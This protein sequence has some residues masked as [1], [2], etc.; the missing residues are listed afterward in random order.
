M[1]DTPIR[2]R[3]SPRKIPNAPNA[4]IPAQ[5]NLGN[6]AKVAILRGAA[7]PD[8]TLDRIPESLD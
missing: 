4:R 7:H 6:I 5:S 8:P 3:H 2:C 1:L